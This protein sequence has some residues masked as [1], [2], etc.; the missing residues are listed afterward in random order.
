MNK[1]TR[2]V[3]ANLIR[4]ACKIY[5]RRKLKL[6]LAAE[7]EAAALAAAEAAKKKKKGKKDGEKKKKKKGKKKKGDGSKKGKKK[8]QSANNDDLAVELNGE[9]GEAQV[10]EG[11]D[12]DNEGEDEDEKDEKDE[13]EEGAEDETQHPSNEEDSPMPR[14]VIK[15]KS[16]GSAQDDDGDEEQAT[17]S[18]AP[19]LSKMVKRQ[20]RGDEDG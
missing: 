12:E 5:L 10:E 18:G 14:R 9:V 1:A 6:R 8:K 15:V 4:H 11:P 19:R 2:K 13:L 17:L 7:A 16:D 3:C 20:K